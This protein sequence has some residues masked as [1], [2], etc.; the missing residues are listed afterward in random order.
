MNGMNNLIDTKT[1]GK[2]ATWGGDEERWE[3]WSFQMRSWLGCL[4]QNAV[5]VLRDAEVQS[6]V[7]THAALESDELRQLS[8]A[9]FHALT[10]TMRGGPALILRQVEFGC[11]VEAWRVLFQRYSSNARVRQYA[12]LSRILKPK[13]FGSTAREFEDNLGLWELDIKDYESVS[14]E[15][16]SGNIKM[17]ILIDAAPAAIKTQLHL[18]SYASFAE[19]KRA[20]LE[21]LI[22]TRSLDAAAPRMNL[23]GGSSGGAEPMDIGALTG[24]GQGRSKPVC[25]TC[26]RPGHLAR[27]CWQAASGDD[28]RGKGGKSM[29]GKGKSRDGKGKEKGGKGKHKGKGKGK[30]P[31][32]VNAVTGEGGDASSSAAGL[33][34]DFAPYTAFAP[35]EPYAASTPAASSSGGQPADFEHDGWQQDDWQHSNWEEETWD[36]ETPWVTEVRA[37]LG[38]PGGRAPGEHLIMIDSG[39]VAH[40]APSSWTSLGKR[41]CEAPPRLRVANGAPLDVDGVFVVRLTL[42]GAGEIL[43]KFI[44]G[45]VCGPIWSAGQL[46][47]HGHV[48]DFAAGALIMKNGV[49]VPLQRRGR[50]FYVRATMA[51][52]GSSGC[53]P[54][55]LS[56][57]MVAPVAAGAVEEA[58][59]DPNAAD[60]EEWDLAAPRARALGREVRGE[61]APAAP[62]EDEK[63]RHALTHLPFAAWCGDCVRGRGADAAHE[64]QPSRLDAVRPL[65]A[66][67]YFYQ[68]DGDERADVAPCLAAVDA[69]TGMLFA[70]RCSRKGDCSYTAKALASWLR[71]LGHPRFDLQS[72]GEPAAKKVIELTR[73][74]LAELGG[75]MPHITLRTSPVESHASN[76]HVERA[77]RTVR[78]LA[79]T[80]LEQLARETGVTATAPNSP[81]VAW[82]LRHAAWLHS[83]FHQRRDAGS[84]TAFERL[85][86]YRYARPLLQFGETVLARRPGAHLQKLASQFVTGSWLGKDSRTDEHLVATL[87]GIVRSRAVRRRAEPD[88]WSRELVSA[89]GWLPWYTADLRGGRPPVHDASREPIVSGPLPRSM[90]QYVPGAAAV[91]AS[92]TGPSSRATASA[93]SEPSTGTAPAA[94]S[95]SS[96]GLAVAA[97][98]TSPAAT[99]TSATDPTRATDPRATDPTSEAIAI[100]MEFNDPVPEQRSEPAP[101]DRRATAKRRVEPPARQRSK[102]SVA[103]EDAQHAVRAKTAASSSGPS[104]T[105]APTASTAPPFTTSPATEGDGT[106]AANRD[107]GPQAAILTALRREIEDE[108]DSFVN[109]IMRDDASAV[110]CARRAHL[111]KLRDFG[112]FTLVPSA[113]AAGKRVLTGTW[114][115]RVTDGTCKSRYV[116]HGFKQQLFGHEDFYSETPHS[117][118]V[119]LLLTLAARDGLCV[120]LGDSTSA[121]LQAPLTE[122]VFFLPPAEMEVEPGWVCKALKAMPGLKGAPVAWTAHASKVLDE[123]HGLKQSTV[124]PCLYSRTLGHGLR[125]WVLRHLDDFL[126]VGPASAV[127]AFMKDG[128]GTL[129]LSGVRYLKEPGD[130]VR[131]LGADVVRTAS[132]FELLT[133]PEIAEEA[134]SLLGLGEAR[135]TRLAS[136]KVATSLEEK[137]TPLYSSEAALYRTAVGKVLYVSAFRPDLQYA[138]GV[139][140][141]ALAQPTSVDMSRLK[142]LARFLINTGKRHLKIEPSQGPWRL[143]AECDSDWGGD[144]TRRSTSGAMLFLNGALIASFSRRQAG[145][146]LSSCEAELFALVSCAAEVLATRSWLEEQ[147]V[148]LE[149]PPTLFTDSSA[150]M[151]VTGRR[152]PGKMKHICMRALAVQQWVRDGLISV[153]KIG[154]ASNRADLLTKPLPFAAAEQHAFAAGLL[155]YESAL[156]RGAAVSR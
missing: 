142:K 95:S 44:V 99:P 103:P 145:Y 46:L 14:S 10:M 41:L 156:S 127:E 20:V 119:R 49:R 123:K 11:G 25:H 83:R 147:D 69:S 137:A 81:W 42:P 40:V 130:S 53:R 78:G 89:M 117:S 91:A 112:A 67:D 115:D 51:R 134:I 7:L 63:A 31:Y 84:L 116:L 52:G 61:R 47:E 72:D 138:V 50:L 76:G 108:P 143:I 151:M 140:A 148:R 149:G 96:S 111:D 88:R 39:A 85:R 107:A 33:S 28:G 139:C 23:H 100:R 4:H 82:A 3:E 141:R 77:I 128:S 152:G 101:A 5:A 19:V 104:P 60:R 131:I 59:L 1:L 144:A 9:I 24:N 80:F 66:L 37:D 94:A 74:R 150:A 45:P 56:T 68:G 109:A 105:S 48:P 106:E 15:T 30:S 34:D 153:A 54:S 65:I 98:S 17:Q 43:S 133:N 87:A 110:S 18:G 93:T 155:D 21:Y 13:P 136:E 2:P 135:G 126:A 120:G 8:I 38:E 97:A 22:A 146:A 6:A 57:A 73:A 121:F 114:V 35:A 55:A 27:D 92:P 32:R 71:E 64:R 132:G 129:L 124:D 36:D 154:T 58:P 125:L 86:N 102:P 90:D 26:G 75:D 70:T 113:A 118:S 16:L 79:R 62:T 12:L 122:E 29:D